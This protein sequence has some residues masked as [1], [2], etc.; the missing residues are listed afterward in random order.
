[1]TPK[2]VTYEYDKHIEIHNKI[3]ELNKRLEKNL[4]F[5]VRYFPYCRTPDIAT[6][7]NLKEAL[8]H[9]TDIKISELQSEIE[10]IKRENDEVVASLQGKLN[11]YKSRYN[12]YKYRNFISWLIDKLKT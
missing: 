2:T 4:L 5:S 1:M 7:G 9:Y 6:Y 10:A 11:Y 8:S 12:K 3:S